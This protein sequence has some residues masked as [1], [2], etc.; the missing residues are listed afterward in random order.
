MMCLMKVSR[1]VGNTWSADRY[2]TPSACIR[3]K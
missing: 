3:Y 1:I 2:A